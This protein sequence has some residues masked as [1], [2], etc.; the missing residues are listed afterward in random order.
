MA[1]PGMIGVNAQLKYHGFGAGKG[2]MYGTYDAILPILDELV[3][4]E[5][6]TV[7]QVR[8][9]N[10]LPAKIKEQLKTHRAFDKVEE[11]MLVEVL[12]KQ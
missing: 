3:A 7:G 1:M 5:I 4:I 10:A 11:I 2:Y 8:N 9:V 6:K 12:V